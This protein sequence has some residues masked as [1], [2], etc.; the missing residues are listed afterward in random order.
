[1]KLAIVSRDAGSA[2]QNIAFIDNCIKQ[3]LEMKYLLILQGP[4][5]TALK[6]IQANHIKYVE[7]P[8]N[9]SKEDIQT[10]K[11]LLYDFKPEFILLGLSYR[12][13]SIDL[14]V[15]KIARQISVKC[16]AIQD[17]WGYLGNFSNENLPDCF[18]L[19]DNYAKSLTLKNIVNTNITSLVVTGSPKHERYQ[20]QLDNWKLKSEQKNKNIKSILFVGQ[21][22]FIEGVRENFH[23][24]VN[25]IKNLSINCLINF[26]IHPDDRINQKFY[27]DKLSDLQHDF[28]ILNND[29]CLEV[30]ILSNDILITCFSTAG[31]DHNYIQFFS[32]K[33]IGELIYLNIG[34]KITNQLENIVGTSS[35]PYTDSGVGDVCQTPEKL[36]ELLNKYMLLEQTSDYKKNVKSAFSAYNNPTLKIHKLIQKIIKETE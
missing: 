23:H 14:E 34:K 18:F 6:N 3:K 20:Y 1:M 30:D 9:D 27:F 26:R 12:P 32:N 31:I 25:Q 22:L 28:N 2:N 8:D 29:K 16:A 17:Y 4:A 36:N 7:Y 33:K 10:L 5:I 13:T 35:L 11:K 19:V 21:P 24:F 15:R